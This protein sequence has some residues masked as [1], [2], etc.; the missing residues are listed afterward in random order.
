MSYPCFVKRGLEAVAKN[1]DSGQPAQSAQADVGR[2]LSLNG[3]FSLCPRTNL[4]RD[5]KKKV[6]IV[7]Q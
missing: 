1:I 2:N 4:P 7:P 6:V 5:L 3:R